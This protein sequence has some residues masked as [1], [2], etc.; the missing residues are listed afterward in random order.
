MNEDKDEE[1]ED[2]TPDSNNNN[3][4]A[5][6]EG[7]PPS[8]PMRASSPVHDASADHQAF[9]DV[10]AAMEAS[11]QQATQ[12]Q[13]TQTAS[14]TDGAAFEGAG[15][16]QPLA[17]PEMNLDDLD[18]EA[19]LRPDTPEPVSSTNHDTASADKVAVPPT[20][21]EDDVDMEEFMAESSRPALPAMP[22]E[23]DDPDFDMYQTS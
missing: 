16:P 1:E 15:R 19:F 8:T 11:Q 23:W 12:A 18:M 6:T 5:R 7:E 4:A 20:N 17:V 22:D 9:D 21:L 3:R 10:F 2:E 13:P 14:S